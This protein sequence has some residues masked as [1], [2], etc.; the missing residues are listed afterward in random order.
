VGKVVCAGWGAPKVCMC[1]HRG[2]R[3]GVG[4]VVG[5]GVLQLAGNAVVSAQSGLAWLTACCLRG[6]EVGGPQAIGERVGACR[7][8]WRSVE[9]MLAHGA[10][11]A[12]CN[13]GH[14]PCWQPVKVHLLVGVMSGNS[15]H[16]HCRGLGL[17][18][19]CIASMC[20]LASVHNCASATRRM[21]VCV[22][23][24]AARQELPLRVTA[25]HSQLTCHPA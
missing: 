20:R 15:W 23:W 10:C 11:C 5:V 8:V 14:T 21:P 4:C 6:P 25:M 17:T 2:D 9:T 19:A 1:C 22:G 18:R 16:C 24:W 3:T 7:G 13:W 12:A